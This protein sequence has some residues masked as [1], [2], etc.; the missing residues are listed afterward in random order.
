M[1]EPTPQGISV[2]DPVERDY[3]SIAEFAAN[4]VNEDQAFKLFSAVV[5]SD[6]SV[7]SIWIPRTPTT[8]STE[9]GS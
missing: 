4:I 3:G 5:W 9:T 8:A 2:F 6:N 1:S 7:I